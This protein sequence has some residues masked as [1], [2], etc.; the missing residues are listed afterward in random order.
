MQMRRLAD[1]IF[2]FE[3]KPGR[4]RAVFVELQG[5]TTP[6][7]DSGGWR[8]VARSIGA[9]LTALQLSGAV[10]R[11]KWKPP[12]VKEPGKVLPA[13]RRYRHR[14]PRCSANAARPSS[15]G[16][17]GSASVRAPIPQGPIPQSRHRRLASAQPASD[18]LN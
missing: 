2:I 3:Q 17:S 15:G 16:A 13:S 9:T 7:G 11:R 14:H 1:F 5:Q 18:R 4:L 12:R 8:H 10:F 6:P